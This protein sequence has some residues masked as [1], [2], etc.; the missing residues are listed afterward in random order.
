MNSTYSFWLSYATGCFV[1]A[2]L[3]R[4]WRNNRDR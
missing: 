1:G 2:F 4:I 3:Y